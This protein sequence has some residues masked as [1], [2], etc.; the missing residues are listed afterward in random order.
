MS[1]LI[2]G[3]QFIGTLIILLVSFV[4]ARKVGIHYG[5]NG[6][7]KLGLFIGFIF[8]IIVGYTSIY[9]FASIL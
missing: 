3:I 8:F 2:V 5:V 7:D 6:K 9:I 4:F 1:A